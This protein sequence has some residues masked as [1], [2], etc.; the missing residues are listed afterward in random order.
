MFKI[1]RKGIY[2]VPGWGRLNATQELTAPPERLLLLLED[3]QF[4]WIELEL[5]PATA[6]WLKS[7]KLEDKRI[8][9]MIMQSHTVEQVEFLQK[10]SKSKP[11][12]NLAET[13]INA[14]NAE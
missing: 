9:K 8:G 11:V 1:T 5:S 6:K 13:R 7:Q 12:Q 4:P 10:L 3:T 2:T 14:L